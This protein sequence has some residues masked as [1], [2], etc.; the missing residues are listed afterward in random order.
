MSEDLQKQEPVI[1]KKKEKKQGGGGLS[2][3]MLIVAGVGGLLLI[4]VTVIF[5]Y[6]IATKLFPSQPVV[7]QGVQ[8]T[9]SVKK[10]KTEE[11][12]DETADVHELLYMEIGRITT[13]PKDA[14]TVFVV[15]N[16]SFEFKP[17]NKDDEAMKEVIGKEGLNLE[18]PII[19]KMQG[20]I[21]SAINNFLA[22]TTMA[23]LNTKRPELQK[24]F[25]E[26]LK[27]TF[28][29]YGF[30]LYNVSLLEFIVQE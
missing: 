18:S 26:L 17:R 25:L 10:E 4:L 22:S 16:L 19:K 14:P 1:P 12:E 3:P 28:K 15:I 7:V 8:Q 11:E 6:F 13:N 30:K 24:L 29:D 2:L 23:E 9:E 21:K 27:P 20:R 5:G